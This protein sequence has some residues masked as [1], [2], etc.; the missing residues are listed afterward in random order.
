MLNIRSRTTMLTYSVG[1]IA[2]HLTRLTGEYFA[3]HRVAKAVRRLI[4][5]GRLPERRAGRT[6]VIF[7]NELPIVEEAFGLTR[8][9]PRD[10]DSQ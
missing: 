7:E 6:H 1:D 4:E 2:V 9:A 10:G 3:T 5:A 8:P